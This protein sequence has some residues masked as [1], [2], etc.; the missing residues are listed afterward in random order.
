MF[1]VNQFMA[2]CRAAF[3]EDQTH[4]VMRQVLARVVSDP[5]AFPKN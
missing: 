1:E 3:A 4:M 2:D 5:V